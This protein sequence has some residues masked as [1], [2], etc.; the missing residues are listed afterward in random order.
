MESDSLAS[1]LKHK[2]VATWRSISPARM[3]A[4]LKSD[5]SN[6]HRTISR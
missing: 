1:R 4:T 6:H 5:A 2:V 3:T